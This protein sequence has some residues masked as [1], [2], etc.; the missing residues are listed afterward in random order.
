MVSAE[1]LID[2]SGP[3]TGSAGLAAVGEPHV[4]TKFGKSASKAVT[5]NNSC[6]VGLVLAF[7]A[8]T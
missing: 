2:R 3:S 5:P 6:A 8:C 4:N 7:Q 1:Q